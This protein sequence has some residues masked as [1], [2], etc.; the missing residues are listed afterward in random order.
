MLRYQKFLA[1]LSPFVAAYVYAV[2][3]AL[4]IRSVGTWI[5]LLC[6]GLVPLVLGNW[7][8]DVI[9]VEAPLIALILFAVYAI[10]LILYKVVTLKDCDEAADEID[11][12]IKAAKRENS[13][14][15][16]KV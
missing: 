7:S 3:N 4:G 15:G 13:R 5:R 6:N 8:K 14:R 10:S 16:V 12:Q 1:V 11:R 2:T 9:I